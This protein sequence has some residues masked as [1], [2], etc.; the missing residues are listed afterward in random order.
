MN[1]SKTGPFK[2][3]VCKES[4]SVK[5]CSKCKVVYYC[6][7]E[8]QLQDWK[9]HKIFC[10]NSKETTSESH[11]EPCKNADPSKFD[12]RPFK[13]CLYALVHAPVQSEDDA[14]EV[15]SVVAVNL[16][17]HGMCVLD[18]L[19]HPSDLKKILKEVKEIDRKNLFKAGQLAGGI[20]SGV[21]ALKVEN[22]DI[23]N[24]KIL[25]LNGIEYNRHPAICHFVTN[26]M[27]VI[28]RKLGFH[29]QEQYT[30]QDR[31]KVCLNDK[32]F[33]LYS[34]SEWVVH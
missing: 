1:S 9:S 15:S 27:D 5:V 10:K 22:K 32:T 2:C 30:F 6:G 8:H 3:N 34:G 20:T 14:A 29:F 26:I 7:R 19:C 13:P 11:S 33:Q 12:S 4:Q 28:V 17:T 31:T 18:G 16:K 25:W 21:D 24:D 23:R